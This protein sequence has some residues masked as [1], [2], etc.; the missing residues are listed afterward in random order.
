MGEYLFDL[1]QLFV[2]TFVAATTKVL[3]K[4]LFGKKGKE[5]PTFTPNQ[6]RKGGKT[7][8]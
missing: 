7:K 5:N 3:A 8:N 6:R 2:G 1:V 4:R